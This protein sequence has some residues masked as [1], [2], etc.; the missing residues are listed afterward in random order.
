M[1]SP[2]D[3]GALADVVLERNLTVVSDEIYERLI[4]GDNRFVSF[5]TAR[6]GLQERTIVVNGVSKAYAMTGWRIGWTL[7]P[8]NVAKAMADLQ[9]QE[10]S[11]PCSISQYA[12]LAALEG[13]QQCVEDMVREFARRRE[14]VRRRIAEMP[15]VSCPEM[16]GA[17]YAF[18]NIRQHLGK[19]YNGAR[20]N[21]S[22]D[23]CLA[24]LE[25]QNVATVMGSAFGAEGYARLSF[26]AAMETL[27]AGLARIEAFIAAAK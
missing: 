17:F 19:T 18:M 26:A 20:C 11:N 9:S 21:T 16:A 4:Y 8:A 1:Y 5:P 27:E 10:T 23:W 15:G 22:A 3:L 12:A 25:Q 2:E 6:P 13:P 14:F 7:S 24:L